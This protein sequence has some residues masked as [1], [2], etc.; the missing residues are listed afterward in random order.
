MALSEALALFGLPSSTGSFCAMVYDFAGDV[1]LLLIVVSFRFFL[2]D[3][4]DRGKIKIGTVQRNAVVC[5]IPQRKR[6]VQ[7]V[8]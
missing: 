3:F 1:L 4:Y 8:I 6:R 7:I 5:Y 2:L